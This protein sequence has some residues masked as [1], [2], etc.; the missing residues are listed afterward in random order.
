M[1]QIF[2]VEITMKAGYLLDLTISDSNKLIGYGKKVIH[3][4]KNHRP[5]IPNL[6]QDIYV[7]FR[8]GGPY[9]K[10]GGPCLNMVFPPQKTKF[11]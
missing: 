7:I 4:E 1:A 3:V 5:F 6:S 9:G 10:K 2:C 8:L 11:E